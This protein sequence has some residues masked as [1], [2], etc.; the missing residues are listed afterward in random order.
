MEI[1]SDSDASQIRISEETARHANGWR[2]KRSGVLDPGLSILRFPRT[3]GLK[4][5]ANH[6]RDWQFLCLQP[7]RMGLPV[8]QRRTPGRVRLARDGSNIAD[9][10]LDIQRRDPSAL[11]GIVQAIGYVL[12]DREPGAGRRPP[13]QPICRGGRYARPPPSTRWRTAS[14]RPRRSAAAYWR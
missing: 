14:V 7:E 5:I 12:P 13:S 2:F 11:E 4:E 6:I 1:E 9:F 10:L 8:P 3:P